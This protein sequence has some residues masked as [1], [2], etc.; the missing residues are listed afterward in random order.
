VAQRVRAVL[1]LCD[2][3]WLA[4]GV[5]PVLKHHDASLAENGLHAALCD[6]AVRFHLAGAGG[7]D[8]A[9]LALGAGYEEALKALGL[10]DDQDKPTWFT[11]GKPDIVKMLD[12]AGGKAVGIPIDKRAAYERS[13]FG[14]QGGGGFALLADPAVREQVQNL[15]KEMNSPE[16]KNRYGTFTEAYK[17]GSTVQNARTALAEFSILMQ[18]LGK[19]ILPA[20]NMALKD[21]KALLEGI[22]NI[23]PSGST[24]KVGARAIEGAIVGGVAGIPGGP[25]GMLGGAAIGAVAGGMEGVAERY[26]ESQKAEFDAAYAQRPFGLGVHRRNA[27]APQ[28]PQIR[29]NLNVDGPTLATS[30]H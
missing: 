16:F 30:V 10:V 5:E 24:M 6:V 25:G 21:L 8:E 29:L 3:H 2:L 17:E 19:T 20:V 12:I 14:A 11:D 26:V 22:R 1:W 13:L 7:K 9:E 23:L 28:M 15:M 18:D 27:P 4:V